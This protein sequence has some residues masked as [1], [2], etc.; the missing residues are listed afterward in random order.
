MDY[1]ARIHKRKRVFNIIFQ[2]SS[3]ILSKTKF[4]YKEK[5][6]EELMARYKLSDLLIIDE[7]GAENIT[8]WSYEVLYQIIN[9]RYSNLLSTIFISNLDDKELSEK[10]DKRIISRIYET[11]KGLKLTGKDYRLVF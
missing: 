11:C 9:Y 4:S 10:L 8:E 7:L 6:T 3:E 1:I 2:T 5:N